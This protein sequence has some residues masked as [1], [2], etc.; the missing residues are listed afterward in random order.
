VTLRG[1]LELRITCKWKDN[2]GT[3][4]KEGRFLSGKGVELNKR[5]KIQT[6]HKGVSQLLIK[7]EESK[8]VSLV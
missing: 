7:L 3:G 8:F 6:L 2:I 4:F 1:H 5:G